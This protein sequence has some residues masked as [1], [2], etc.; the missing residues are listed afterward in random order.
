MLCKLDWTHN[1]A[2]Q[3]VFTYFETGGNYLGNLWWKKAQKQSC[4]DQLQ[5]M[6]LNPF[7]QI[8]NPI[9]DLS[10]KTQ[11]KSLLGLLG[12]CL[13]FSEERTPGSPLAFNICQSKFMEDYPFILPFVK[14]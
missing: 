6:S 2:G 13:P 7:L 10:Q 3:L 8:L 9:C 1:L 12:Q 4:R 11:C 14:F 5:Q